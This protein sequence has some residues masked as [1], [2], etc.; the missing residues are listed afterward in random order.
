MR[1]RKKPEA[2]QKIA[3]ERIAILLKQAEDAA[4]KHPERSK[5]YVALAKKMGMRYNVKPER[6]AKLKF[7]RSCSA[8]LRPGVNCR[9]RALKDKQSIAV[10]CL[11]C[12]HV[13]RYPYIREKRNYKQGKKR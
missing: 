10:T 2:W 4:E 5:R 6:G 3:R 1:S 9:I 8:L 13:S 12:G 11:A 7:C